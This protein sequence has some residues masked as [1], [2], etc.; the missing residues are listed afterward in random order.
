VSADEPADSRIATGSAGATY[1][2]FLFADLRGYTSFIEQAGNAAGVELLDG[3]LAIVRAAVARHDG[4]EIK[5]EGDGFHAVFPSAS[6]AVVC[7]LEIVG[8]AAEASSARPDRPI[9]VGIGIHAGEAVETEDGFVGSAVNIA[10]R[11]CATAAAGEVLV[12]ATVRAITQASIP[13]GFAGRGR[14]RLKGIA[15]PV[16]LY[17]IVGDGS[18]T[19]RPRLSRPWLAGVAAIAALGIGL[20]VLVLALRPPGGPAATASVPPSPASL[21]LAIGQL[22]LG[23]YSAPEFVPPFGLVISDPGWAL[24]RSAPDRV[25]LF[26]E[27]APKGWLD[28]AR[29]DQ[30]YSN[31]CFVEGGSVPT[32]STALDLVGA[33][34]AVPFLEVGASSEV[35]VGGRSG[36]AV[37]FDVVE[38]AQAACG[39][40]GGQ[41]V[42]L[43]PTGGETWDAQPGERVRVVAVDV[44]GDTVA[45]LMSIESSPAGSVSELVQFFELAGRVMQSVTF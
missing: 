28:I 3:Y 16:Q 18:A 27:A 19:E 42:A 9:R 25:G 38:G 34:E 10:A 21:P 13:V 40:F 23:A 15:D 6:S 35:A 4:A 36:L 24:Y 43:F 11:V 8:A 41:G 2:C 14:R 5:V 44:A 30:L 39:S 17:A 31:P 22:A 26:H 37:E 20:L 33:L 45:F 12:T 1:R 29:I 32:G 7:G